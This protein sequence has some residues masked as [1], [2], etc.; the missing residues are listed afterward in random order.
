[1]SLERLKI[2]TDGS[3]VPNPGKGGWAYI[4]LLGDEEISLYSGEKYTTNN[5]MEM[6]AVIEPLKTFK[7]YKKFHIFSDSLYVINCAQGIWKR[8][9]NLD[10]WTEYDKLS[11]G[12][13]ILFE[14]VKGHNGD[15][16]NE[17]VDKLAKRGSREV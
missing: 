4:A 3:C 14:W 11:K 8:K 7:E 6:K 17:M 16:Y 9:A 10:L 5:K 13:D 12:K 15:K 1:M 2:Y